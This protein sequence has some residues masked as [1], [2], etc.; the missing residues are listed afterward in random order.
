MDTFHSQ[1]RTV[2]QI[3]HRCRVGA[4]H[5]GKIA[6]RGELWYKWLLAHRYGAAHPVSG[7]VETPTSPNNRKVGD[8][9]TKSTIPKR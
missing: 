6:D 8:P 3:A 5:G 9:W 2:P 1:N 4:T 7:W